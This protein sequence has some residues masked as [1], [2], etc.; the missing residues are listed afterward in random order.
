MIA[1]SIG[2]KGDPVTGKLRGTDNNAR[3]IKVSDKCELSYLRPDTTE[4]YK[5]LRQL[6]KAVVI[7]A[8]PCAVKVARTV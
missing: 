1:K 6:D 7:S 5:L 2:Y 4:T 3:H 8:K